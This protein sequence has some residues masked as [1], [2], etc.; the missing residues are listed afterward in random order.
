MIAYIRRLENEKTDPRFT[1]FS[2]V[3]PV[4]YD[5]IEWNDEHPSCNGK[6]MEHASVFYFR[7]VG[8]AIGMAQRLVDY[9]VEHDIRVVDTY[10]LDGVKRRGKDSMARTLLEN[11]IP[12]PDTCP[13][14][15]INHVRNVIEDGD[16][17]YPCV[18]KFS[19]GGRRGLG[20]FYLASEDSIGNVRD[21]LR[22]RYSA[23]EKG[24][25]NVGDWPF[26]IQEYIPNNGDYRAITVGSMCAGIVKRGSKSA[27]MLVFKSSDHGARKYKRDRWPRDVGRLAVQAANAMKVGVSGVDIVRHKDTG[28]LYVIEVNE[29]PAFNV[30]E[31]RTK[32]DV[33]EKIVSWL[34][35]LV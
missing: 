18:L 31:R 20:T 13:V 4:L 30:F 28:K 3:I 7:A 15:G 5:H 27:D 26:V 29:T 2:D 14:H 10:L 34:R 9:A 33:A 23:G 24:H 8:N 22:R 12:Q 11:D 35:T 17:G 21:E 1:R 6:N 19:M 25:A 16:I 32:I